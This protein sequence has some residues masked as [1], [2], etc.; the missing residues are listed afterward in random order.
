M[1]NYANAMPSVRY[2]FVVALGKNRIYYDVSR[3]S[4]QGLFTSVPDLKREWGSGWNPEVRTESGMEIRGLFTSNP[5]NSQIPDD[6]HGLEFLLLAS[7]IPS[8]FSAFTSLLTRT[9]SNL[10]PQKYLELMTSF[11]DLGS[12][13]LVNAHH[14]IY[15]LHPNIAQQQIVKYTR[16]PT[17]N[18]VTTESSL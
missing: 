5:R 16:N 8:L 3:T 12:R 18:A 6:F 4:I 15:Q 1:N 9:F 11:F 10:G 13:E 17:H 7:T 14:H 2:Q